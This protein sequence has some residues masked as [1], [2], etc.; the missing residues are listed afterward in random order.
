MTQLI[1]W[2]T[3]DHREM[4][5]LLDRAD[6]SGV[7]DLEA[8]EAFRARILRHI[9]I[10][11]KVLFAEV[12][13]LRD[14]VPLPRARKLRLEHAAVTSLLVPTPDLALVGELRGLLSAHDLVEEG[15]DGVY[16]ECESALGE[17]WPEVLARAQAYPPVRVA[18]HVDYPGCVRTAR[19]ALRRAGA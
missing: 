17:A 2:L 11:E 10:E 6:G 16:A 8:F 4:E 7:L 19:E 14:G 12:R 5:A 9:A 13:R 15:P 18:A 3:R 1:D